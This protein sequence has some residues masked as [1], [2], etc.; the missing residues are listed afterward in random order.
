[1]RK[2]TTAITA[3]A[4]A[5]SMLA[6][7][8]PAAAVV[9]YDS[10]YAGES[11]FV[12]ITAGQ[13]QNFQVFFANTGT[14]AWQRGT[15]TQVDLAACLEDKVT[16]NAQ[17]ASEAT[18]NSG[19]LSATRYASTVQ[20]ITPPGS[21][22][23]FSYNITAPAGV[24]AGIYR[25]NGDLVLASTGEKI[26]PDGYYQEANTGA[27]SGAPTITSLTPNNGTS[28]GGTDV[29]IAGT[30]FVCTP[31]FPTAS[32]GGTN[33]AVLSCGATSITVDSPAHAPGTVTVT[34]SNSGSGAS[35][36]L[37]YTYADTSRPTFTSFTVSGSLATV[38]FSEPVC[39]D[40]LATNTA[41]ADWSVLNVSAQAVNPVTS[42]SIPDCNAARDNGVTTAVLQLT[43]PLP[44]GSF[45]EA[46]LNAVPAGGTTNA[47]V[48]DAAG[49]LAAAPQARQAT[50][51]APETDAPLL[52]SITGAVGATS[53]TLTFS[54][55]VRCNNA[56]AGVEA[57]SFDATDISMTDND[58]ATTDPTV[59]G[60]GS[61]VCG[62]SA[63]SADTSF[64]VT[65]SSGLPADRT[66]SVTIT[67]DGNEL[68][69]IVGND[70]ANPTSIT[71]V[72]GA[73]DF[74]PP[75]MVD[76]RMANNLTT[77]NFSDAGDSFNTTFSEVMNGSTTGTINIQD[78]DGTT[79]MITCSTLTGTDL[80]ACSWNTAVTTLTV[81]LS[82]GITI[83]GVGTTPG[84]QIPFNIT[85]LNGINDLQGN[86]SNVLGSSDRLVDFE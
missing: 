79:A 14:T 73:S 59:T 70:L 18:W 81:T 64:S 8:V 36:G 82:A 67:Q 62:T 68:Q 19:W 9:G 31:A 16:C 75:T 56:P 60:I 5:F 2:I 66:Y 42:D 46:T 48:E 57:L 76:S 47:N 7:A 29:V 24:A 61:N 54:E 41:G 74:T 32:F 20:T 6:S 37:T 77:T 26:H 71:F 38:T 35:N 28:N 1:M 53:M 30:G 55:P 72:T 17:D 40:T 80:A 10:A 43:N 84:M 86:P 69:D 50:A 3:A 23:T 58:A 11:A 15:G 52:V 83:T 63:T 4:L 65:L 39:S 85:A 21:L 78:Q 13:T 27:A 25:F 22:G 49:N 33:G 12:N 51:T 34:V 45:V 44:N